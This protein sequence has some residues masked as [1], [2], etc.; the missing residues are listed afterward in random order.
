M[1]DPIPNIRFNVAKSYAVLIDIL[2]RLPD[3][4][5]ATIAELE[6]QGVGNFPGSE[7]GAQLIR[8]EFIWFED[9]NII[10]TAG[11]DSEGSTYAFKCHKGTLAKKATIFEQAFRL[12]NQSGSE[13]IDELPVVHLTDHWEDVRDFLRMM[14]GC[15]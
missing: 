7:R 15:L 5:N 10:V 2:K 11:P 3:D 6:K 4:S 8:D 14:Y 13:T 9:G 1:S 12:P